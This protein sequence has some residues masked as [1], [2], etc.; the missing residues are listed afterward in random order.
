VKI[1]DPQHPSM[2]RM[3]SYKGMTPERF[4]EIL[5]YQEWML[6][7]IRLFTNTD[8]LPNERLEQAMIGRNVVVTIFQVNKSQYHWKDMQYFDLYRQHVSDVP[9]SD[10]VDECLHTEKMLWCVQYDHYLME[11]KGASLDDRR[12]EAAQWLYDSCMKESIMNTSVKSNG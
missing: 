12:A 2:R 5:S 1:I 6:S 10:V 3:R 11:K 4:T 7:T 8:Q 9:G